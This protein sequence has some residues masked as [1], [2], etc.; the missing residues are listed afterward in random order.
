[1]SDASLDQARA[2]KARA[3]EVFAR[4]G[5]VVGVGL[6]RLGAGYAIKVNFKSTPSSPDALPSAIDGVPVTVEVVGSIRKL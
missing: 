5:E 3:L 4:F 2:A 1:M 6:V